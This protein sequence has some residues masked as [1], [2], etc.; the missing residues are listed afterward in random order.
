[1]KW[2][3]TDNCVALFIYATSASQSTPC[4]LTRS[5]IFLTM[6][7]KKRDP[8]LRSRKREVS[9][10]CTTWRHPMLKRCHT[11]LEHKRST[12]WIVNCHYGHNRPDTDERILRD[13]D[14]KMSM[15]GLL[16]LISMRCLEFGMI[17]NTKKQSLKPNEAQLSYCYILFIYLAWQGKHLLQ[18]VK[19]MSPSFRVTDTLGPMLFYIVVE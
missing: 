14:W 1:M 19:K 2:I 9:G 5:T 12:L 17:W 11:L 8:R 16:S 10:K 13:N 18:S 4:F 6:M 3:C 7:K 15:A